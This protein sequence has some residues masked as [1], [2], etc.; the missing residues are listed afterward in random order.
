MKRFAR[1]GSTLI[2]ALALAT[3]S[4]GRAHADEPAPPP[5]TEAPVD[6]TTAEARA[7]HRRGLELYDEGDYR[8]ALVEF[9]RA[10]ELAK[11]YKTLFNIGQVYFQLNNYAK[12]RLTLEQYLQEGGSAIPDAR[13]AEVEKDLVT[14]KARTA[15]LAVRTNVPDAEVIIDDAVL[16]K[17]PLDGV[18][19]NAGELRVRVEKQGFTARVRVVTLAGG[20]TTTV[21]IDMNET[22]PEVVVT[23]QASSG[24][25]GGVVASWIVTGILAAGTV[26]TG[27]AAVAASSKYDTMRETPISGSV[28][29]ARSDLERQKS[30]VGGLAVTTDILAVSTI[31]ATGISLY[32]T[33]R[34]RPQPDAPQVRVQGLGATFSMGF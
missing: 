25:P 4:E 29:E 26:G 34:P 20:D 18:V 22:K 9:Q 10:Y 13:R 15:T 17:T 6:A 14:L 27:I 8:L 33:F 23:Q 2:V 30:L 3:G 24:V 28:Q 31:V 1:I 32:L 19:V 7:H 5:T 16:G 12:A 21:E 11:S